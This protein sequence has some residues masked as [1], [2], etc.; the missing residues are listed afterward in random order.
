MTTARNRRASEKSVN[1]DHTG[2]PNGST[3]EANSENRKT[4]ATTTCEG[5]NS[6]C[7]KVPPPAGKPS[8]TQTPASVGTTSAAPSTSSEPASEHSTADRSEDRAGDPPQSKPLT[9]KKPSKT[10]RQSKSTATGGAKLPRGPRGFLDRPRLRPAGRGTRPRIFARSLIR[11]DRLLGLVP[12]IA[13]RNPAILQDILAADV[14]HHAAAPLN[15]S[16]CPR[17]VRRVL[18]A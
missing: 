17:Y 6:V 11:P 12:V 16:P 5:N 10:A 2:E 18:L 14:V 13:R 1:K 8:A 9:R 4:N 7:R 3:A 15:P